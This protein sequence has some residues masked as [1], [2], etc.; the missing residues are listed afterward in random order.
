M[1]EIDEED[2]DKKLPPIKV[3]DGYENL[4]GEINRQKTFNVITDG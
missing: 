2:Y 4:L 3:L 1:N